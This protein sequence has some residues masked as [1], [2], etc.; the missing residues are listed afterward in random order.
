[1]S[2]GLYFSIPPCVVRSDQIKKLAKQVPLDYLLLESD[3]PALGPVQNEANHPRNVLIS[4][5][6]IAKIK[7]ISLDFVMQVTTQNAQKLFK[8]LK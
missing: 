6:E 4:A 5:Q 3:A 8:R 7:N 1:V 2:H